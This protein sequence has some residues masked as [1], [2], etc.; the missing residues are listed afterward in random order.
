VFIAKLAEG[1]SGA[2]SV[3]SDLR[4]TARLVEGEYLSWGSLATGTIVVG[5]WCLVLFVIG[6]LIFRR[7]ELAIYSG[8]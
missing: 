1:I 7:R 8:H 3:Y 2:F 6:V 4:P 5:I